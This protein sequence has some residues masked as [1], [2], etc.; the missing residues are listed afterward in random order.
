MRYL[1]AIVRLN[2]LIH[3]L[4]F[5]ILHS[6]FG[7]IVEFG[8]WKWLNLGFSI[9]ICYYNFSRIIQFKS[10][11][12]CCLMLC[13]KVA[14]VPHTTGSRE[15]QTRELSQNA[16]VDIYSPITHASTYTQSWLSGVEMRVV[17]NRQRFSDE[18]KR[19]S[20]AT[21]T[22]TQP[23]RRKSKKRMRGKCWNMENAKWRRP[24]RRM[25]RMRLAANCRV[26]RNDCGIAQPGT[27]CELSV[28]AARTHTCM[29]RLGGSSSPYAMESLAP[30]DAVLVYEWNVHSANIWLTL[31]IY[32]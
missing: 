19:A 23:S 32:T 7:Y 26:T 20:R 27:I 30:I 21:H 31:A 17:L 9:S 12:P 18:T 15:I 14:D 1:F 4:F 5:Y 10:M 2:A 28:R 16:L 3:T 25:M 13:A 6:V 11:Q 8:A 22:T 24:R 29:H